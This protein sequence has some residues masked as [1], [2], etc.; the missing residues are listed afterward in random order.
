[1]LLIRPIIRAN[2]AR[3]YNAHVVVFF[4]FLVANIG[5]SLTPLGDPPLFLGFLKGVS[6]F[7]PTVHLIGPMLVVTAIVLAVFFVLDTYLFSLDK[8]YPPRPDPTPDSRIRLD[9]WVNVALLGAIL[10]AVL[11]SGIWKPGISFTINHIELELQ[12]LLRDVTLLLI[13][14]ISWKV[15]PHR[16]RE[17]N[18]FTWGPILEV[19]KLFAGIFITIIPAIA[20]LRAGADGALVRCRQC[21]FGAERRTGA[22][23]PISGS[24]VCSRASSTMRLPTSS[25]S[26]RRAAIRCG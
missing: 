26:T 25:S 14:Y 11:L 18:G 5:G 4:I 22:A 2:D 20:I 8:E 23:Q 21:R 6:F 24:P 16:I 19:A 1:M 13:T 17:G 10:L 12:N 9:G 7:W 3:I 15:T